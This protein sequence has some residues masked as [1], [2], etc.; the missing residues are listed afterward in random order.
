MPC[1]YWLELK[2]EFSQK[3]HFLNRNV[4]LSMVFFAS[5]FLFSSCI[6]ITNSTNFR[7]IKSNYSS[8]IFVLRNMVLER[9]FILQRKEVIFITFPSLCKYLQSSKPDIL[10]ISFFEKT[11]QSLCINI[12]A[13]CNIHI[14]RNTKVIIP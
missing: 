13:K 9:Q 12:T 5:N 4:F 14:L 1:Y 11:F 10:K 6:P 7:L 3:Q 8:S 2:K